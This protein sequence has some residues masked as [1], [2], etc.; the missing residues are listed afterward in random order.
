MGR[1]KKGTLC[2][3]LH[4]SLKESK[5]VQPSQSNLEVHVTS[6]SLIPTEAGLN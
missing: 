1:Q 5:W 2:A 3:T 4:E 6:Q